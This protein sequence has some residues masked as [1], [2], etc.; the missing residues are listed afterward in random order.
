MTPLSSFAKENMPIIFIDIWFIVADYSPHCLDIC[1][2]NEVLFIAYPNRNPFSWST[3]WTSGNIK[4]QVPF[5]FGV[6]AIEKVASLV[7]H[8]IFRRTGR[9][10]FLTDDD[11]EQPPLLQRMVDDCGDLYFMYVSYKFSFLFVC[12]CV[13]S[14]FCHFPP[15][16]GSVHFTRLAIIH[17]C[18]SALRAFKRRVAYANVG[19]DRIHPFVFISSLI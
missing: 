6:T 3:I 1:F 7:I 14:C 2:C 12:I 18:R 10:L 5:L 4:S 13:H 8:W 16:F 17:F 19:Y 15:S 9:H 11:G